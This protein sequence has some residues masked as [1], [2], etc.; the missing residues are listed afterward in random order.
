MNLNQD[1]ETIVSAAVIFSTLMPVNAGFGIA[2][3]NINGLYEQASRGLQFL[4]NKRADQIVGRSDSDFFSARVAEE[5]KDA[6]RKI[7]E[8]HAV[9]HERMSI[10][11]NA[12]S[13]T[14]LWVK[15]PILGKK[16]RIRA[17]G[18]IVLDE[19]AQAELDEMN[20]T[21]DQL[22][23]ANDLLQRN[24]IEAQQHATTDR[25]T[26]AWNRERLERT[27]LSE[28][29]RFKRYDNPLSLLVIDVDSFKKVNDRYGHMVGDKV[30]KTLASIIQST[31]RITDSL[32]RWGGEEFVV[33]SPGTSL[34]A[35][36]LLAERLREQV[37][38]AT[39]PSV[40]TI[41][42][43]IGVAECLRN[44][45]WEAWFQRADVALYRAK[46]GG[47][48]QVQHAPE[49]EFLFS[50][51]NSC[52]LGFS[53]LVWHAAYDCGH[54]FLD[55]QHQGLFALINLSLA[56]ILEKRP[57]GEVEALLD[58]LIKDTSQHFRDEEAVLASV[59]YSGLS[60]H[61]SKHARVL[62]AAIQL[63]VRYHSGVVDIG[64]LFRFLAHELVARHMLNDDCEFFHL[65]QKLR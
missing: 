20:R 18:V 26:G 36:L 38:R 51:E 2:I 48:N 58:R 6:D 16:R 17:I 8:G 13:R 5:L 47:R 14:T 34:S 44:E 55:K 39:Y 60:E 45:T 42:I 4:L 62:D 30:L 37:A 53:S 3:K 7:L 24:L 54:D 63:A 57:R 33:L 21:I 31:L 19:L 10:P 61:A 15:F 56:A 41:T 59:G 50:A 23:T 40:K 32:T 1:Q 49:T 28:M 12:S 35:M 65:F 43:S 11:V 29:E 27:V 9:T 46:V 25:L 64:E 22:R 52:S